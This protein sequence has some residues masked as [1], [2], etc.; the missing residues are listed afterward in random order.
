MKRAVAVA[1]ILLAG[2]AAAGDDFPSL[3]PRAIERRS[4][5][6]P[7][8]VTPVA[9]PDAGLNATLA[10]AEGKLAAARAAF[11]TTDRASARRIAAAKGRAVGSDAWLDAQVALAELDEHRSRV[12][13][14]L[15]DL[16]QAAV[17]RA[18]DG[19]P[20]YPALDAVHAA[21]EAE[22][23]REAGIVAARKAAVPGS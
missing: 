7:T 12:L 2:C 13:D 22:L 23:A 16:E 1:A 4:D 8:T 10:A 9:A 6:E 14:Q 15:A 5:A 20:P 21:A 18:A 19:L 17:A 11:D 3:Q